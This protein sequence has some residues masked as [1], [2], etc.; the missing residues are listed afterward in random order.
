MLVSEQQKEVFVRIVC[1]VSDKPNWIWESKAGNLL[2]PVTEEFRDF[3]HDCVQLSDDVI[4]NCLSVLFPLDW[5][6]S[7]AG[8]E[9]EVAETRS[10]SLTSH[11]LHIPRG[12]KAPVS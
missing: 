2:G 7:Q 1:V 10:S 6:H 5:L 8:S 12:K 11:E 3:R 9:L 4:R